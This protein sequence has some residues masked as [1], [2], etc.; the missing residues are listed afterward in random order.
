MLSL[1][2]SPANLQ[3][4]LALE[5][6]PCLLMLTLPAIGFIKPP[7]INSK[8]GGAWPNKKTKPQIVENK[9]RNLTLPPYDQKRKKTPT[10]KT[11]TH[12]KGE[13]LCQTHSHYF[14]FFK[15]KPTTNHFLPIFNLSPIFLCLTAGI[16]DNDLCVLQKRVD[17]SVLRRYLE[18]L[19]MGW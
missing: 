14:F 16:E 12:N 13:R 8:K 4:F 9:L 11:Q 10:N 7:I 6:P 5:N 19:A 1:T 15:L 2:S 18:V 17:L 3:I